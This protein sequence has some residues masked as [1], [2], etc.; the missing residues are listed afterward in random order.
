M[1]DIAIPGTGGMMPLPNRFLS[2]MLARHNGSMILIDCGEGTQVTLKMLGWGFKNIDIICFTHYH[3]DHIGGLAGLLL[4]I[5]AS[6]R[7]EPLTLIGPVD[8]RR[9][10]KSLLVIA[11]EL[12]F[13]LRFV[14]LPAEGAKGLQIEGNECYISALPV[15]HGRP[16]FAYK[17][18]V[19]RQGK[20]DVE[21]AKGLGLPVNYWRVLQN[22]ENVEH[23]GRIYTPD[24]VLGD[25]RKGIKVSFC[26]DSRPTPTLPDF[27][28]GSDLFICEGLYGND[29]K[30]AKATSHMHMIY[31]EA[32]ALAA[33]GE[34]N[35]M[36]LTHYSPALT[37]PKEDLK[38][39]RD[40]FPNTYC[41]YD[42][43]NDTIRFQD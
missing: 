23:E 43:M 27:I 5:A 7:T 20:F 25:E 1:I 4:T 14:E 35:K 38:N 33:K 31:S 15:L 41:G 28:R 34:V 3:A 32:A 16:C 2:T 26:T 39:A 12:P 8:L 40:I 29:E 30:Q 21:K 9:V 10:V 18:E 11:Q 42:R 22:G 37:N 19:K 24:M 36:W 6:N 13:E 17:L